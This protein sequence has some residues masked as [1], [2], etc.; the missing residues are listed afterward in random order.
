[1]KKSR[2]LLFTSLAVVALGAY[3][4]ACTDSINGPEG[5][6]KLDPNKVPG[7]GDPGEVIEP[8]PGPGSEWPASCPASRVTPPSG[9]GCV[10]KCADC[11]CSSIK[12]TCDKE[13][14]GT[15]KTCLIN[16]GADGTAKTGPGYNA[17]CGKL[18]CTPENDLTKELSCT[19]SECKPQVQ[20][21]S[22]TP[23]DAT[24]VDRQAK[25]SG[26]IFTV[27]T[28]GSMEERQMASACAAQSFITAAGAGKWNAG[29]M[30]Q[31]IS[32]W[33]DP[34]TRSPR[35]PWPRRHCC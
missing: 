12:F 19:A 23:G 3:P 8:G 9:Q 22:L 25:N 13:C 29:V 30:T 15:G 26:L 31:D 18:N 35:P 17:D 28:S 33:I 32:R 16:S 2:W 20:S 14:Y 5:N 7:E 34:V 27:D 21:I 10:G 24:N 4:M 6:G 1:M 11:A